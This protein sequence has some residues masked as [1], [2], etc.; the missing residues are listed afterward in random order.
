MSGT[1]IANG[2][3]AGAI[4]P[5]SARRPE[6]PD[7][8]IAEVADM[9]HGVV[10]LDQLRSAGLSDSAVRKRAQAGRLH[11][12]HRGVYAVGRSLLTEK[13][14]WMAAVLAC[15]PGAVLSH[16]SAAA[17]WGLRQ[18]WRRSIDVTA[19]GRR[20]RVPAGIVAHRD[21]TLRAQDRTT[22]N[23]IP[24]ASVARTLLDLAA[25]VS[26]N[27][28][29][30]EIGEAEVLKIFD[31]AAM[32]E[33]IECS[34]GRRGVARLRMGVAELD[35]Q[36]GRTR[37][38]MER[39]FLALCRQGKLPPPEVNVRLNVRGRIF[40]PDFLW[41]DAKLIIETDGRAF[42]DTATAFERDRR[43]DQQLMLDGWQVARCTWW[44]IFDEPAEVARIVQGLLARSLA[45]DGP[46]TGDMGP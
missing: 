3:Q 40:E 32:R 43:R 35:P 14:R 30:R 31:L 37:N 7:L 2:P 21:G 42:H 28:L 16:R 39:R 33:V 20:G 45:A 25:G 9:Q 10:T 26:G 12:V 41:R 8:A 24:C 29:R 23:G 4:G 17:L 15:G 46:Q 36:T 44:Q 27:E 13:G 11:R 34:P 19:P 38:E 1:S 22:V 6:L 18:D 5:L